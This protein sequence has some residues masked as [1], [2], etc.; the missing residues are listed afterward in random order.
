MIDNAV[1]TGRFLAMKNLNNGMLHIHR[2][3]A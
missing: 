1:E 3:K 2:V